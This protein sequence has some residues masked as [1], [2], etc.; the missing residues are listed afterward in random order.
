MKEI[1]YTYN[2]EAIASCVMIQVLHEV[3]SI[4]IARS[5]LLLP[6]LLDDRTVNYLQSVK[7]EDLTLE[8]FINN[9]PHLFTT[10]NK[11][12]LALMPITI[13]ALMMLSKSNQIEIA[14]TISLKQ[15][16]QLDK[17][18]MGNRFNEIEKILSAFLIMME[19]HNTTQLY[20]L[21]NIQL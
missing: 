9:R 21:L 7:S 20:Q 14:K 1:Y 10:F 3:K 2:N 18:A 4:D 19:K 8:S 12:F 15:A 6:F 17:I 5:C 13:N 11:R 16:I